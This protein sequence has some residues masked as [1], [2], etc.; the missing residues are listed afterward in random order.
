M[1]FSTSPQGAAGRFP[2]VDWQFVYIP[3][4]IFL[5]IDFLLTFPVQL[6]FSLFEGQ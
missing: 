3:G 1:H 2:G 4:I 5:L 6:S